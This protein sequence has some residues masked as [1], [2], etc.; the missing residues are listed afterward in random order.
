MDDDATAAAIESRGD[1]PRGERWF[2]TRTSRVI[3]VAVAVVY[4]AAMI[5]AVVTNQPLADDHGTTVV[6]KH[7]DGDD[8]QLD[9]I[10]GRHSWTVHV[11]RAAYDEYRVGDAYD[12]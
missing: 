5:F 6:G 10:S 7:H 4:V 8:W 12:E 3:G 11:D 1:A 9:L 2:R